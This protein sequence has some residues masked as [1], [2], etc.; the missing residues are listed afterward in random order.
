M[1]KNR[2]HVLVV[3][4]HKKLTTTYYDLYRLQ[5]MNLDITHECSA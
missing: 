2:Q 1:K 5:S 3:I 4:T